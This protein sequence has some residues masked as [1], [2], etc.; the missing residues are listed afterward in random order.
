MDREK[1]EMASELEISVYDTE[2]NEKARKHRK[3]LVRTRDYRLSLTAKRFTTP[4]MSA[5]GAFRASLFVIKVRS[6]SSYCQV[7]E[8]S[9]FHRGS[10][11][12]VDFH[13]NKQTNK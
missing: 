1:E 7:F 4:T 3:E 8:L 5:D 11:I 10:S 13:L 9:K 6:K 12:I 2:R